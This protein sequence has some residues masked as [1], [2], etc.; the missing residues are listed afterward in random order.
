M[1]ILKPLGFTLVA[2]ASAFV[3]LLAFAAS[4]ALA[5]TTPSDAFAW[6]AAGPDGTA[7][8]ILTIVSL[9][10]V[11]LGATAYGYVA[12]KRANAAE[13]PRRLQVLPGGGEASEADDLRKAA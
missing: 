6:P 5:A 4:Q 2:L 12:L 3:A 13:A 11:A 1:T 9:A 8:T 10:I 7:S